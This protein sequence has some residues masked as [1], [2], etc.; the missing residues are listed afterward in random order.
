M[1]KIMWNF[2]WKDRKKRKFNKLVLYEIMK[3]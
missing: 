2:I 1:D 3:M